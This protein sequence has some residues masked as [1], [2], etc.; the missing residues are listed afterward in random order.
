MRQALARHQQLELVYL[1]DARGLQPVANIGR[2]AGGVAA[3]ASAVGRNW[4]SRPW[5]QQPVETRGMAVSEVYVSNA[6][7][8]NCITVSAPILSETGDLLGVL[9]VDVNLGRAT[10]ERNGSR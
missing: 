9:G 5:F 8:E 10:A 6:T 7:G 1:T 4:S 2:G 3:D